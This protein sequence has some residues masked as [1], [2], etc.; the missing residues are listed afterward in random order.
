MLFFIF[1]IIFFLSSCHIFPIWWVFFQFSVVAIALRCASDWTI[2]IYSS[3]Y[4]YYILDIILYYFVFKSFYSI[5]R[6]KVVYYFM[7]CFSRCDVQSFK[8]FLVHLLRPTPLQRW[9]ICCVCFGLLHKY[10]VH[11]WPDSCALALRCPAM[12]WINFCSHRIADSYDLDLW[13]DDFSRETVLI[14]S[15]IRLRKVPIS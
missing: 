11:P 13:C 2:F 9:G 5:I 1:V 14:S 6:I 10:W 3:E 12:I 8:N 4:I 15:F 7:M